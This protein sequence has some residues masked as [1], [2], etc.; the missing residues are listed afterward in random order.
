MYLLVEATMYRACVVGVALTLCAGVADAAVTIENGS[1]ERGPDGLGEVNDNAFGDMPGQGGGN[2]WDVWGSLPGWTTTDGAGIEVQTEDT[3]GGVTPFD[4]D[5]YVELDSDPTD[6]DMQKTNSTMVQS[7]ELDAGLYRLSYA[8]QPR[9]NSTGDNILSVS[10]E[11]KERAKLKRSSGD[12]LGWVMYFADFT[13]EET[14]STRISF[15][16]QGTDNTLGAFVDGVELSQVP[17]P[18][19]LPLMGTGLAGLAYW[20]RRRRRT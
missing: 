3:V 17:V 11:G 10:V 13:V 8:Y 15:A 14:G 18:A 1:F 20:A 7:L 6:R 4:G 19:A 9:T 2:S 12:G 16:A 5:Y